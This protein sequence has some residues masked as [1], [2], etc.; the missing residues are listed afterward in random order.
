[1]SK[2][3]IRIGN[4]CTVEWSFFQDKAKTIPLALTGRTL[5]IYL[6]NNVTKWKIL[7]ISISGNTVIFTLLGTDQ[8]TKYGTGLMTLTCIE[9]EGLSNQ[10][11]IDI[12]QPF[13]FVNQAEE[14]FRGQAEGE[15][16]LLQTGTAYFET[17]L[18]SVYE[19]V[20]HAAAT[21]LP[22]ANEITNAQI[23]TLPNI[24]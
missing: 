11:T 23:D 21:Y 13:L 8:V 1:M 3:R 4:D 5:S 19:T 6:S 20:E 15:Y 10:H 7:P 18:V 12:I 24:Q 22:K 16:T 9:N 2:Y 14:G 17:S